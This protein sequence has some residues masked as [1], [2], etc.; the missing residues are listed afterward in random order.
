MSCSKTSIIQGGLKLRHDSNNVMISVAL[1]R[2]E[3]CR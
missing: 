2:D 1:A 3:F